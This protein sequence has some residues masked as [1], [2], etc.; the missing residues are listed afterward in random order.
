MKTTTYLI[1]RKLPDGT[2][3]LETATHEEWDAI[4]KNNKGLPMHQRRC[5]ILD[6]IVEGDD[7]DFMYIET[8]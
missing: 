8:T 2:K 1:Y 5:F 4:M 7:I 3:Q 6:A